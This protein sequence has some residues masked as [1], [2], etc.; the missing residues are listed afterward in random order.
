ME[1]LYTQFTAFSAKAGVLILL[2]KQCLLFNLY[3]C[4]FCVIDVRGQTVD[5]D[6]MKNSRC[7]DPNVAIAG[8]RIVLNAI[9]NTS[10]D[11]SSYWPLHQI[12]LQQFSYIIVCILPQFS[13]VFV[14]VRPTICGCISYQIC[15]CRCVIVRNLQFYVYINIFAVFF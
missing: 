7:P 5:W 10:Q 15:L 9:L 14:A 8:E 11:Y 3:L 2:S 6:A 12:Y 1:P 4:L 13:D